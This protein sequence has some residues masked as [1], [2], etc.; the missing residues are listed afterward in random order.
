MCHIFSLSVNPPI[1]RRPMIVLSLEFC[2]VHG[3][4]FLATLYSHSP[5]FHRAKKKQW[6]FKSSV[7]S[8]LSKRWLALF[9]VN[10]S[11]EFLPD[12]SLFQPEIQGVFPIAI[13]HLFFECG[14]NIYWR[15]LAALWYLSWTIFQTIRS[16][17][18]KA[19]IQD[20]LTFASALTKFWS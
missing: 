10:I 15:S 9:G 13:L 3:P 6:R 7:R 5:V 14:I 18:P 8:N 19:E 17:I 20:Q 11:D 12:S 16:A 2:I 4:K 1:W